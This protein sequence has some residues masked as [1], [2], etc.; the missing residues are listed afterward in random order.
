VRHVLSHRSLSVLVARGDRVAPSDPLPS[1]LPAPYDR[2]AF[3][4]PRAAPGGVS[5]L[6]S[7]ILGA[8][9]DPGAPL[10]LTATTSGRKARRT[11]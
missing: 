4:D 10:V 3:V 8:A 11:G 1:S 9:E 7:K 2:L 5:T 6:A